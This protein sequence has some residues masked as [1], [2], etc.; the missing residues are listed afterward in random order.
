MPGGI[1]IFGGTFDPPHIAHVKLPPLAADQLRCERIIYVPAAINPLKADTPPTASHHRLAMLQLAVRDVPRAEVSTIE[2]DR[3]GPS[4]M[5][6]TLEAFRDS[7]GQTPMY[8]LIGA[9]QAVEFHKWR[10]W[11]RIVELARP[12]VMIRPPWDQ[13]TFESAVRERYSGEEAERWTN[14][15]LDLPRIDVNA[16]E[17]RRRLAAGRDVRDMLRPQVLA[18]IDKHL[19]YRDAAKER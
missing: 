12:A 18:Y 9:D 16:T 4:Y 15:T 1:L 17:V 14:W 19:L 8:L 10:R 5:V 3:A 13:H 2:L 6:D 11:D 7:F